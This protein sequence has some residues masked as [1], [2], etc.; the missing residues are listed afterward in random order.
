MSK[1]GP[2]LSGRLENVR[3]YDTLE[4]VI[5]LKAEPAR[6]HLESLGTMDSPPPR[7]QVVFNL[8]TAAATSQS[9]LLDFLHDQT[10][11]LFSLSDGTTVPRANRI[12]SFWINNS[13]KA[14]V[15]IDTLQEIVA[16]EDVAF[17]ELERRA[18]IEEL[19][20]AGDRVNHPAT[21]SVGG[22]AP[23]APIAWS[24]AHINAPLVW[25]LGIDGTGVI[26][27]VIDTGV[28]YNHPDLRN[29][30]WSSPIYPN[31]GYD[32]ESS[33]TDPI[34][35]QGH[36]TC[37]A[38]IVAGDGTQGKRTG[39]APGAQI[40]AIRVGGTESQF[41]S[42]LQ[43]AVSEGAHVIS[44]SMTWK[45]PSHPDYPGWRR[46]CETI[47]A[48]AVLHA[49]SIGNQGSDL[50]GHPVPFNIATPGNCPPPQL[51]PLQTPVGAVSSPISCGATT[52]ADTLA[53]Y[54]GRGP[55]AWESGMYS[56]YPWQGGSSP[57]LLKPDVC[58]PGPG[59]ESCNFAFDP[60]MHGSKPYV[61]FGGTSAATPHVGGC[62][63]LLASACIQSG[64]PI[65]PARIQEALENTAARVSGQKV[66]K[67][68]HFGAGRVDV[69][70]AFDYG[71]GKGWWE[72]PMIS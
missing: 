60:A 61:S 50:Q 41:W 67:E 38:G 5:F 36:G 26:V 58:A 40:M 8:Q 16:R 14:E 52:V 30:M 39:V 63:A 69:K 3:D 18:D 44:M 22:H 11:S 15:S 68:N 9:P 37:C 34:D 21:S 25:Q 4:V 49:N 51:H 65:V 24:V 10:L 46:A 54:S 70:A 6:A 19:L 12:E 66:D 32:F 45:Y 64:N 27:A 57:G 35:A 42:G 55:A 2:G 33:D 59:T 17:V 47:L 56:D 13:I 1:I 31:H 28:N 48:A 43:F 29:R 62:L 7:D 72:T 20:D 23:L 71:I 53:P